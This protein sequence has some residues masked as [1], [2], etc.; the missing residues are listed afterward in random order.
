MLTYL[1]PGVYVEE[2]SSGV[3][4]I[5]GVPTSVTAFIGSKCVPRLAPLRQIN[6]W[7]EYVQLFGPI[8]D[9]NDH[10]ALSVYGFFMNGGSSAYIGQIHSESSNPKAAQK[11]ID[12]LN[13]EKLRI[14]A[15]WLGKCGDA[16][17][18]K[19][20]KNGNRGTFNLEISCRNSKLEF[21][22]D[23]DMQPKSDRYCLNRINES[24]NL[25][26]IQGVGDDKKKEIDKLTKSYNFASLEGGK[27][28]SDSIKKINKDCVLKL[29][30][31]NSNTHDIKL[32]D[33]EIVDIENELTNNGN[34]EGTCLTIANFI[35]DKIQKLDNNKQYSKFVFNYTDKKF[36]LT[37]GGD[38]GTQCNS[39]ITVI[40]TEKEENDLAVLLKLHEKNGAIYKACDYDIIESLVNKT[41]EPLSLSGG[42][43]SDPGPTEYTSFF[44]N[45]LV[46]AKD[47]SILVLPGKTATEGD[48]PC[49]D[50]AIAHCEKTYNSVVIIDTP[51]NQ[52]PDTVKNIYPKQ[53]P[54]ASIYYPRVRIPNP[55]YNEKTKDYQKKT[56]S[57]PPSGFVAG[58]WSR[59]DAKRGVWK[60]PAGIEASLMGVTGFESE[61]S[62]ADQD[63]L[64]NI[65]INCLRKMPGYGPVI[66][67][68]R[69]MATLSDPEWR[70]IPVR[71]TA[72]MIEQSIYNNIQWAVFEPNDH[73]LW[74]SLRVNIDSFMNG[75]WRA[76]AFQGEKASDAY[77][78]RCKLGDT[79]TQGDIDAGRVIVDVGF[80]PV[81]PAEFVIIRIQ[82]KV[83]Q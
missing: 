26:N 45:H 3:K 6:R 73:R 20:I 54:F 60:A 39:A 35:Q 61:L 71:R 25:I 12:V 13:N 72:I 32:A 68:S 44:E 37:A 52:D 80:A 63:Q 19:I 28:D 69:T 34:F 78:V 22:E 82:Q 11:D 75:L 33:N 55:L 53:S 66:W 56:I 59:I 70:Y 46:K 43:N 30:L 15:Q 81:K 41:K 51:D 79:M 58:V 36:K 7:D 74:S 9:E 8:K 1:H 64:N 50:A 17:S 27:V 23:L 49:I 76:G 18:I 65:G 10:L 16:L 14:T 47:V 57:A 24:S 40:K 2:V 83:S 31:N 77:F 4:P 48:K 29:K 21:F 42:V 67:G 62:D 38:D 5:E